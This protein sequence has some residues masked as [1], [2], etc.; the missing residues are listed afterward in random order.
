[1]PS[2]NGIKNILY[3]AKLKRYPKIDL[4]ADILSYYNKKWEHLSKFAFEQYFKENKR[5]KPN[6]NQENNKPYL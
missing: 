1:M 4:D 2:I 5:R 6:L 3:V